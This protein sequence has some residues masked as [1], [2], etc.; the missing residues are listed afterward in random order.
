VGNGAPFAITVI[1]VHGRSLSG[2]EGTSASANRVRQKRLEQSL[3]LATYIQSLQAAD[4]ARRIVVTGDFNAFQFS[5]G[6][7]DVLGILT[8]NLDPNGAIQAGHVDL[9][10]PNLVDRV[11]DAPAAERYSFVF[12]GS[13]QVLDHVLTSVSLD[14]YVR[15]FAFARGN[16]DAPAS[17]QADPT[18]PLRTADHDGPAL[19]VMTDFD[20]DGLPD[21]VDNCAAEPNPYQEDYDGDGIG[22][23]CDADDDGDG[24]ADAAD[25]CRLSLPTPATV[26][27]DGCDSAVPDQLL[28][29]G[30]S[31]TESIVAIGDGAWTHGRFVSGVAHFTNALKKDGWIA[32][33]DKGAI[34]SC[35]A[36]ANIP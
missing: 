27:I 17:L 24:V 22:D 12:D 25:A 23:V 16:A 35:A 9:V 29:S 19:F 8:G 30:C 2:I 11:G 32:G 31:I 21:D 18:T 26:V 36:Q 4:P 33:R 6:Y 15:G 3:E 14:A 10:E 7:V 28:E 34:Q 5:D 20:A 13:A 1:G